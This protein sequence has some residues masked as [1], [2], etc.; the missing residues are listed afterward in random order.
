MTDRLPLPAN[1]QLT[2][3]QRAV[4]DAIRS[5]PRGELVGPF[6]PLLRTPE[7]CRR[8][9]AVGEFV[10]YSSRVPDRHVELTVLL[11]ARHWSQD[12]EWGY[13]LPIARAKGVSAATTDAIARAE[14]PPDLD[15]GAAAVWTLVDELLRTRTVSTPTYD[16]AV[17]ELGEEQV[18][19][20]VATAGY[21][22]LLA[23]VMNTAQTPPPEDGSRLPVEPQT[24]A[25]T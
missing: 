6:V 16:R 24:R 25:A 13:H 22:S 11:V 20:V 18:V 2:T 12:F 19:E 17:E 10:R 5:G 14:R 9:Q 21:Y 15:P 1:D 4:V 8:V 3:E 7:L 23:M